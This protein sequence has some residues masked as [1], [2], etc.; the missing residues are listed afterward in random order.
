[1]LYRFNLAMFKAEV[2]SFFDRQLLTFLI[3]AAVLKHQHFEV[4]I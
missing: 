3:V 1:M 2:T 4:Y